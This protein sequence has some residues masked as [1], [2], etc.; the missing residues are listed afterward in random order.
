VSNHTLL[1]FKW[2][3]FQTPQ[4]YLT[5]ADIKI[6]GTG[7][8]P[9]TTSKTSSSAAP[10]STKATSTTAAT[11][12]ATPVATVAVTFNSK[13]ATAVGQ[14]IKIAG[15][16]AQLGSWDTSRA[17]ALSAS[18][19]T[20]SNPLWTTTI[21]LPAGTS[22]E[23]KFIKLESSGSV[24]YESGTNRAYTVPKSCASTATVDATWK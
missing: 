6:T 14:T 8:S 12:C 23:Y 15:S 11:G 24:S 4:I 21:N 1:S 9:P 10:T 19:Y 13:T 5:C 17:Q 18:K 2:N 16:I 7:S 22:F 20:A 3:S